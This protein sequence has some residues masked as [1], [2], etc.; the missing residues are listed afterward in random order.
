[1]DAIRVLG[2]I[3]GVDTLKQELKHDWSTIHYFTISFVFHVQLYHDTYVLY[4]SY[5]TLDSFKM[6]PM[7]HK[8]KIVVEPVGRGPRSIFPPCR[9]AQA[10]TD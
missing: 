10:E 5:F 7:S 1:M 2:I 3:I 6:L 9:Q 8:T 4:K